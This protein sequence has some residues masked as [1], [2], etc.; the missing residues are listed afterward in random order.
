MGGEEE[1]VWVAKG[2]LEA[3]RGGKGEWRIRDRGK[4]RQTIGDSATL[5]QGNGC[6]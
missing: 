4:E 5:L 2:I 6:V 1:G 3:K